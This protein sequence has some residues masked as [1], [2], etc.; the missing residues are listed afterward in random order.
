MSTIVRFG[1]LNYKRGSWNTATRWHEF[2]GLVEAV[3]AAPTPHVLF[4]SECT[5]WTEFEQQPLWDAVARLDELWAGTD[6][7]RP[8]MSEKW[9]HRNKPG[10]SRPPA[11]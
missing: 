1:V 9:G 11:W 6:C 8:W 2:D 7:Y 3:A 4:L 10:C 5:L